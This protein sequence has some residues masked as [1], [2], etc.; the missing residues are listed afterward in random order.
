MCNANYN[1]WQRLKEK[2]IKAFLL[3]GDREEAVA[4]VGKMVG[5]NRENI[6]AS[7]SPQDK[8]S[9]ISSLRS[10][11]HRVAMV[12][13]Y[14]IKEKGVQKKKNVKAELKLCVDLEEQC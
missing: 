2:G 13:F 12:M 6:K 8:A 9:I 3:S 5:L 11:G 1:F 10:E 7:L 14:L 4:S